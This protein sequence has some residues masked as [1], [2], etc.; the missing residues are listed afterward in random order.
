MKMFQFKD[1]D[2][3]TWA[4]WPDKVLVRKAPIGD[5]GGNAVFICEAGCAEPEIFRIDGASFEDIV[6]ELE[7]CL[8]PLRQEM[9]GYLKSLAMMVEELQQ[10]YNELKSSK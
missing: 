3:I 10:E 7:G 4:M 1:S 6:K 9:E 8:M 2:G 5:T